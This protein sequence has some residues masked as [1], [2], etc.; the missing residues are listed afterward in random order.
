MLSFCTQICERLGQIEDS[1][2]Q[3]ALVIFDL[4]SGALGLDS[5]DETIMYHLI[6]ILYLVLKVEGRIRGL[7]FLDFVDSCSQL[8]QYDQLLLHIDPKAPSL[9]WMEDFYPMLERMYLD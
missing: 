8:P 1:L 9:E 6:S 2:I 3:R 4:C 5:P 7:P